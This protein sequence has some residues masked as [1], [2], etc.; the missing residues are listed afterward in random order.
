MSKYGKSTRLMAVIAALIMTVIL[1]PA[2]YAS[3]AEKTWGKI[4]ANN[5]NFRKQAKLSAEIWSPLDYGWILEFLG[6]ERDASG[7]TW[8]KVQGNIPGH[9]GRTYI[10]FIYSSYFTLLNEVEANA[11]ESYPVQVGCTPTPVPSTPTPAPTTAPGQST[12]GDGRCVLDADNVRFRQS[13][14]GAILDTLRYGTVFTYWGTGTRGSDGYRWFFVQYNGAKGYIR[15]DMLRFIDANGKTT[16]KPTAAPSSTPAPTAESTAVPTSTQYVKLTSGGIN[17][18]TEP[19]GTILGRLNKNTILPFYG[20]D[21][22]GKWALVYSTIYGFGYVSMSYSTFCDV[23]GNKVTATPAPVTEK[24]VIVSEGYLATSV[25]GV[26]LRAANSTKSSVVTILV[27]HTVVYQMGP[28]VKDSG[29]ANYTW[30]PVRTMDGQYGYLRNDV[31]YVPEDWQITY[32]E[33]TGKLATP[34]P[35]VKPSATPSGECP[36]IRI[37]ASPVN[38]RSGAS[39]TTS[40]LGYVYSGNVYKYTGK[41]KVGSYTWYQI[42]FTT[43]LKGYVRGDLVSTMTWAEYNAWQNKNAT[44]TPVVPVLTPTPVVT[45]P[46]MT[47]SVTSSVNDDYSDMCLC[48]TAGVNIREDAGTSYKSVGYVPVKN[49]YMTYLGAMRNDKNGKTWVYVQYGTV[50]GWMMGTY[51]TIYTNRQKTAYQQTGNPDVKPMASYTTLSLGSSGNAV[52]VLQ[53]ELAK[54]G[55]LAE[56]QITGQYLSTTVTA[57]KAFQQANG[58]SVDGVAGAATQ[59]ALFNTV[60]EGTYM[61]DGSTVTPDLKPVEYVDWNTGDIQEVWAPG[62]TAIVTDVRSGISFRARRWSGGEHADVEPLTAADT[63]AICKIFNVTRAQDIAEFNI[64][65]RHPVWVTVGGR[66]FCGSMY[67]VPHN[68]PEGDTIPDNNFNGQFCVHFTNSRTHGGTSGV[69]KV[70]PDHQAAIKYAYEHSISGWK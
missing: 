18:R 66:T 20:T 59:H 70:D 42:Q 19:D 62:T 26:N 60:P 17:F 7:S 45:S 5:V 22:S 46:V 49:S 55:Y 37:I 33:R 27:R 64:Y 3:A 68:Y 30:F 47:P 12:E 57:V 43:S 58:L 10:G 31:C 15:E 56:S 4:T 54:K 51:V 25:G 24:P 21:A 23:S 67:G 40:S 52:T 48:N 69:R 44:P 41:T 32:W 28:E 14:C 50:V 29:K 36:Y 8:Y 13:P 34:I 38:V 39:T 9:L 6:T 61:A 35:T 65:E 2:N 53:K 16:S 11:W 63:A 1:L